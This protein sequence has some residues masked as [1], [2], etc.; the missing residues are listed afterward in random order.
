M[1]HFL[2]LEVISSIPACVFFVV[3]FSPSPTR[4]YQ[5]A[6]G[7]IDP[8]VTLPV[9]QHTSGNIKFPTIVH[10]LTDSWV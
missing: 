4:R 1:L 10:P 5:G 2:L 8:G 3:L 9:A 7:L 6:A